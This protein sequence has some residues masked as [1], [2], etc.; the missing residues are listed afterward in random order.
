MLL[1]VP[2]QKTVSYQLPDDIGTYCTEGPHIP[3]LLQLLS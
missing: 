2:A 1:P 3:F